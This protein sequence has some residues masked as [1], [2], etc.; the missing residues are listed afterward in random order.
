MGYDRI[1]EQLTA[2]L[3]IALGETS[4]DGEFTLLPVAC[5]GACDHAPTLMIGEA[6]HQDL[7]PQ[8]LDRILERS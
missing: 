8:K 4:A 5:L 6:L 3:G 7:E 2:R 1:R